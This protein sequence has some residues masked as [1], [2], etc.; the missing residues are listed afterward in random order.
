MSIPQRNVRLNA[1]TVGPIR[2]RLPRLPNTST[3]P[4]EQHEER[5]RVRVAQRAAFRM[6]IESM[7]H[8]VRDDE[9]HFRTLGVRYF[10]T[11]PE[12]RDRAFT[13]LRPDFRPFEAPLERHDEEEGEL[14]T[15]ARL[16][17][18]FFASARAAWPEPRALNILRWAQFSQQKFNKQMA[19]LERLVVALE[20]IDILMGHADADH[21]RIIEDWEEEGVWVDERVW[22]WVWSLPETAQQMRLGLSMERIVTNLF[23][24][25][26]EEE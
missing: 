11:T 20:T 15:P 6:R 18:Q 2:F 21:L 8:F 4:Y 14:F 26:E 12:A 3:T 24:G 22:A 10:A 16:A 5:Q 7:E 13:T 23:A 9:D 17:R 1:Q 25:V 19:R